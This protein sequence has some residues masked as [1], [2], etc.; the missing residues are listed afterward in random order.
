MMHDGMA[1]IVRLHDPNICLNRTKT[2][3]KVAIWR[4]C[5][6][7]LLSLLFSESH[8]T[9]TFSK[10]MQIFGYKCAEFSSALNNTKIG[11]ILCI[12]RELWPVK[13]F[14]VSSQKKYHC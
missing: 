8:L 3:T 4:I 2:S 5:E 14:K 10:G 1:L 7:P 6:L 11:L 9:A 13:V 12:L